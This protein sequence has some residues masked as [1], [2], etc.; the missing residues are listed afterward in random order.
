MVV[1]DGIRWY[2]AVYDGI[3][4][5]TTVYDGVRWYTM[6][7]DGMYTLAHA[8]GAERGTGCSSRTGQTGDERAGMPS[9]RRP[10]PHV[11]A[12]GSRMLNI[13]GTGNGVSVRATPNREGAARN[14]TWI[15][16]SGVEWI[17]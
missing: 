11:R 2:M 9:C 16:D 10:R 4:W 3:R 7:Y 13:Y 6:V 5:Y 15:D 1:Y 17:K 8:V 12:Q 14:T